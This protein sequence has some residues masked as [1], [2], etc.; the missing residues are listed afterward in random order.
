MAYQLESVYVEDNGVYKFGELQF[1]CITKKTN[2]YAVL[3]THTCFMA[4]QLISAA[5]GPIKL[6]PMCKNCNDF[7]NKCT[8]KNTL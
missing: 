6:M 4:N 1:F 2:I 7:A 8:L 5:G 3:Q